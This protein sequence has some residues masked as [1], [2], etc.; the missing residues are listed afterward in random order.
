MMG[1][2][3]NRTPLRPL[4]DCAIARTC[5]IILSFVLLQMNEILWR[6]IGLKHRRSQRS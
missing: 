1:W 3:C 6:Q 5:Y 2:S 4:K